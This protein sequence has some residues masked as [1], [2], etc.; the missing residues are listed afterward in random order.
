MSNAH[1]LAV[2]EKCNTNG[3]VLSG[4]EW[5]SQTLDTSQHQTLLTDSP[6]HARRPKQSVCTAKKDYIFLAH[7]FQF[8]SQEMCVYQ[9]HTQTAY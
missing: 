7:D 8:F 2:L 1:K 9:T 4:P 5:P 3:K 6:L